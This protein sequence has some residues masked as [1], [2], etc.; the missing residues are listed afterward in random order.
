MSSQTG[1]GPVVPAAMAG[2]NDPAADEATRSQDQGVPV[3]DADAR[4]D[5][6]QG[7]EDTDEESAEDDALAGGDAVS[8]DESD[9]GVPVGAADAEEDRLRASRDTD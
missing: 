5:A 4:A 1:G 3:G 8:V 9:S 2:A 7:R 6:L